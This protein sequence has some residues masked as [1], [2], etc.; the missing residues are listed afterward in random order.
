MCI[1]C[2]QGTL[3]GIKIQKPQTQVN[4]QE[5]P[6]RVLPCPGSPHPYFS[7]FRVDPAFP[8]ILPFRLVTRGEDMDGVQ[9]VQHDGVLIGVAF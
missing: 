5:D 9:A 2:L 3:R 7:W 4:G 6:F 8:V 1:G